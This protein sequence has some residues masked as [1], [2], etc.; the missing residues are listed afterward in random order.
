MRRIQRMVSS[1]QLFIS[2]RMRMTQ[3]L[4]FSLSRAELDLKAIGS[5]EEGHLCRKFCS[6]KNINLQKKEIKF[7]SQNLITRRGN[8]NKFFFII[9]AVMA[10]GTVSSA[11]LIPEATIEV[12]GVDVR[13]KDEKYFLFVDKENIVLEERSYKLFQIKDRKK[14]LV[15]QGEVVFTGADFKNDTEAIWLNEN[16]ELKIGRMVGQ[17]NPKQIVVLKLKDLNRT[18]AFEMP[19]K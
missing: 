14:V 11:A 4:D 13:N 17:R 6:I 9:A 7:R 16:V 10:A 5:A 15:T 18:F 1:L 2:M 8:M 12:P 3:K 19:A